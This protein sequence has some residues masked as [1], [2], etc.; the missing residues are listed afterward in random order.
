MTSRRVGC[1]FVLAVV[2]VKTISIDDTH[3]Q[4]WEFS[5][6]VGLKCAGAEDANL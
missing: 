3:C 6:R 2:D 1:L 4:C 5:M